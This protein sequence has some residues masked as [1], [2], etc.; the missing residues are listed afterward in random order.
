MRTRLVVIDDHPLVRRGLKSVLESEPLFSVV[1]EAET[2]E[3]SMRVIAELKPDIILT[4]L[5]LGVESGLSL[6]EQAR[7]L[8]LECRFVV[9]T[10]ST[11][12]QDFWR[13]EQLAVSGYLLK[14]ALPEEIIYAL[15]VVSQG[16]KY[17]D[18]QILKIKLKGENV[19]VDDLTPREREVL[20]ALGQGLSNRRIAAQMYVT[21]NTVKKHVSQVLAK[22]DLADRTQAAL[23][24]HSK[25]LVGETVHVI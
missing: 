18:P 13:A 2:V 22:L 25:G 8:P 21:E 4:D 7:T 20:I 19:G 9:L 1:G 3:Q 14:E 23:Y 12:E 17:Y 10:S 15:K 24:A 11:D 6:I 5:R 16:R